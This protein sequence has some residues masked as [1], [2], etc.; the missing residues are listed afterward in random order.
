MPYDPE[1]HH[2]RSVRLRGY[3]YAE[4]GAYFVTI[5][6][7]DRELFFHDDGI[8]A[9]AEQC[10]L[11]I[12]EHHAVAE[13]DEWVVMPNHVHGIVIINADPQPPAIPTQSVRLNAPTNDG[14]N[15]LS[16]RLPPRRNTLGIIVRTYKAAATTL[17]RCE[18]HDGFGWQRN[19]YEHVIRNEA[20]LNRIRRYIADNP[21]QWELD[22]NNPDFVGAFN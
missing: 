20:D 2:R 12:P 22:E 18:G 3:N 11:A 16:P 4:G 15:N 13:L 21:A 1:V 17:C 6:T 8:R 7:R 14:A 9:I 19:Y 10:L 5:C